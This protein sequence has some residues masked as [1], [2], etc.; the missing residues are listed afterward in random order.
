[1]LASEVERRVLLVEDDEPLAGLLVRYLKR[2]NC[3]AVHFRRSADALAHLREAPA[4]LLITD[5]TLGAENGVELA[6]AALDLDPQ[7]RVLLMSGYPYEPD[8]FP[9]T[10]RVAFLQ[11]PFLPQMLKTEIERLLADQEADPECVS[12]S[13][14]SSLA[15][16]LSPDSDH[17]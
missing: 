13:A 11:K 8:G 12:T 9:E 3:P 14:A 4:E 16:K 6:R 10:A 2:L 1:M 17:N 5:L 15:A 7:L